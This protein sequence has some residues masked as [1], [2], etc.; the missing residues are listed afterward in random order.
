MDFIKTI[1]GMLKNF[2]SYDSNVF[3]KFLSVT[4]DT[5]DN[6][7]LEQ[8]LKRKMFE[9]EKFK[10]T[11]GKPVD[12]LTTIEKYEYVCNDED[13]VDFK[14]LIITFPGIEH[15]T[16]LGNKSSGSKLGDKS[17][18]RRDIIIVGFPK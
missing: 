15:D 7:I 3:G 1:C 11:S 18:Y 12:N 10:Q 17:Y 8:N 2:G 6:E 4:L 13:G 9:F 16:L 5:Q 14:C